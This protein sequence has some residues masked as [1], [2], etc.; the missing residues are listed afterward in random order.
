MKFVLFKLNMA[1]KLSTAGAKC[2]FPYPANPNSLFE[3]FGSIN[4]IGIAGVLKISN[5]AIGGF[6]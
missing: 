1:Y 3:Y 5:F 2:F 6:S 4:C